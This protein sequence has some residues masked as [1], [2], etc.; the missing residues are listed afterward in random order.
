MPISPA[1]Q[2]QILLANANRKNIDTK[3]T[4]MSLS[5]IYGMQRHTKYAVVPYGTH[6]MQQ[7]YYTAPTLC[8]TAVH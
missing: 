6:I 3:R 8:S 1:E 2:V 5:H 7:P 4:A